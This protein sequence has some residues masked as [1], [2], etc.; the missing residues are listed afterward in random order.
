MSG[1]VTIAD[2]MRDRRLLW[3]YCRECG[4]ERELDPATLL[5]PGDHPVPDVGTRMRC[6]RAALARSTRR[7]SSTPAAS[8]PCAP[9]GAAG[10]IPRGRRPRRDGVAR[11]PRATNASQLG[12]LQ[13]T[14]APRRNTSPRPGFIAPCE[15]KLRRTPPTGDRWLSEIKHDGYRVQAH[16][17]AGRPKLFTRRGYDWTPRFAARAS[18][19]ADLPANNIVLDGEVIVQGETGVADFDALQADLASGLPST[20]STSTA[21]TCARRRS[22]RARQRWPSFWPTPATPAACATATTSRATAMRCSG[23]QAA[24]ASKASSPSRRRRPIARGG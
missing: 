23:T 19:L 17:E 7:P 13:R 8:R 16:L 5:L 1:P 2:L 21:S 9:A 3:V 6:R 11:K 12:P 14:G 20:C 10:S 18:A 24:L 22:A 4:R 15:P